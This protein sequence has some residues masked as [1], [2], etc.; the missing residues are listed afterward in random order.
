MKI[1]SADFGGGIHI[2]S[3]S[4][5]SDVKRDIDDRN[6][7]DVVKLVGDKESTCC[8]KFIVHIKT[9]MQPEIIEGVIIGI[10]ILVNNSNLDA[11]RSNAASSNVLLNPSNPAYNGKIIK[12]R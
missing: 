10:I 9:K 5:N 6:F 7:D 2:Y 12:G 8:D 4:D 3:P 1:Y 11:P